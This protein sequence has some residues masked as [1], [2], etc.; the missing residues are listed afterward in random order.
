MSGARLEK[1]GGVPSGAHGATNKEHQ[2][3]VR[4][5]VVRRRVPVEDFPEPRTT[6]MLADRSP[7]AQRFLR[8]GRWP[9]RTWQARTSQITR[10]E[11]RAVISAAS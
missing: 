10:V 3:C 6:Q 7:S 1:T 4:R 11:S 2:V 5:R 8:F 9:E